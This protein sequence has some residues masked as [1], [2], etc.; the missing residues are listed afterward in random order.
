MNTQSVNNF[1]I[2]VATVN[3]SGSQSANLILMRTLFKMGIPVGGKNVFPSNIAGLP[4]W[5]WI[6]AN[7]EGFVGRR[8]DADIVIAMNSQTIVEDTQTLKP[9]G[10]FIYN[11]EI[12]FDPASARKD[13]QYLGVPFKSLVDKATDSI[14]IKKLLVNMIYVGVVGE[15]LGLSDD[16]VLAAM[17]DQ[18]SGKEKVLDV[19]QKAYLIGREYV[20]TEL[21]QLQFPF[22][23]EKRNKTQGKILIDG[24]TASALGLIFGGCSFVAWYPITPSSSLVE[25]FGRYSEK[26]RLNNDGSKNFA[27]VQAEDELSSIAM[28][29]GAGWAGA[30]AMTATSGPGLSL[31]N[32]AAGFAYYAEIPSVIWD[33]QRVG[34]S[35]GMPTRTAQ[36]DLM[37]AHYASHGDTQ[38]PV[39]IPGSAKE[40][41]EFGQTCFDLAERLQ[42]LVF[43]LSD[44]DMGM[45]YWMEDE[46]IYPTKPYDRG[47]VLSTDELQKVTQYERYGDPDDDGI[48][49]RSLP[50]SE[51]GIG[52]YLTRGSGHNRKG[53]YTE[54]SN[55]YQEIMDRL[56]KKLE[57]AR[58][59]APAP[60]TSGSG[61]K[62]GIISYGSSEGAIKEATAILDKAGL[63]A[64]FLRIRALPL[65]QQV[66]DFIRTHEI[67]YV[68]DLNRDAQMLKIINIEHPEFYQKLHS[69]RHY[70]GTPITAESISEPIMRMEKGRSL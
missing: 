48:P 50:G 35:T 67:V 3:G 10:F 33:V 28:V 69:V 9:G 63:Q 40:C 38:H 70:D 41:F 44:L 64:D 19:N 55:E 47:K 29:L 65:S 31:M 60:V 37:L 11:S 16:S 23:A 1:V 36:G 57:T 2:N 26:L 34:P 17:R 49:Y 66:F 15:L 68:V 54:K 25:N 14:K 51:T 56:S 21:T 22:K 27:V 13:I 52:A 30:R 24:N 62:V 43:V 32:E 4:T 45:N 7:E 12:K 18:F 58:K 5:F 59:I 8:K 61:A 20:K 53:Q 6:R 42:T 39:L 46:F